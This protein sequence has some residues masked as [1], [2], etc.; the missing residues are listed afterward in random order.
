MRRVTTRTEE[1]CMVYLKHV[2][3]FAA[4]ASAGAAFPQAKAPDSGKAGS[5][6]R[7]RYLARTAGCNDCHTPGYPQSGGTVPEMDWLTGERVGWQGGWGTTYAPN[8]RL[9]LA[10]MT[11]Q[12]W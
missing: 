2:M 10:K 4:L 6:E 9:L 11:E 3:A 8:L 5:I 12:Q 7:G 1:S